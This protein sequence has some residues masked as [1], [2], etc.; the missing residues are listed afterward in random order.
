[1]W[2]VGG[3]PGLCEVGGAAEG[4]D[5]GDV[6]CAGAALAFLGASVEERGDVNAVA[7]EEDPG[8][9]R[10]VHFVAGD[11]EEVDVLERTR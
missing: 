2:S 10:G 8:A 9:L 6:F 3:E 11:A 5:A 4:Y 1:V 7:H